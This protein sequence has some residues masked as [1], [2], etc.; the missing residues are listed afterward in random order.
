MSTTK[1]TQYCGSARELGDSLLI[2]LNLNQLREI[3]AKAENAQFRSTF[4]TKDGTANEVLKLK[5][6]KRKEAQGFSTHFLCLND[7]VKGEAKQDLPF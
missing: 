5:A 4:T 7:Y 2:D 1:Q 3:L 6:V